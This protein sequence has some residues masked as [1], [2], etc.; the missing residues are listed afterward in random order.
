[1]NDVLLSSRSGETVMAVLSGGSLTDFE[2]EREGEISLVGQIY[3][4]VV[5]RSVSSIDAFFVDIGQEKHAFLRK[6]DIPKGMGLDEGSSVIVQVLKD[7]TG[8]KGPMVSCEISI[9]GRYAVLLAG[10]S[11][12]GVSRKIANDEK[13]SFLKELGRKICPAGY[14]MVIRTA[15]GNADET[16]LQKDFEELARI[17]DIIKKRSFRGKKPEL[18]YRES[19]LAVR[20]FRDYV[21][22]RGD[23]IIT[24][25]KNFWNMLQASAHGDASLSKES[26]IFYDGRKPLLSAYGAYEQIEALFEREVSLPSGGTIVIDHTEALTAIDVNSGSFKGQGMPHEAL[27]YLTNR[28]AAIEI[29]RQVRLRSIGGMIIIDFIDMKDKAGQDEIVELLRKETAKDRVKT[30]V[31]GMTRLGL[32]EMTRTR[33]GKSLLQA[34]YDTCSVCGGTGCILSAETVASHITDC[35]IEKEP[36]REPLLVRCHPDVM[37]ILNQWLMETGRKELIR[38]EDSG[39][40]RREVYS[41]L[42]DQ[43]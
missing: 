3:R 1:M 35:I 14:G 30:V 12:I 4:G 2:W 36:L 39:N 11:Y 16:S 40:L 8:T 20:A 26:I 7:S 23:K 33:S 41:L 10:S 32:V 22:N 42:Q 31:L 37:G 5:N 38:L 9:P 34:Y 21:R 18:L 43:M 29:A 15:A 27:A 24:D 25:D 13:R 19:G 28:E 6:K 17:A